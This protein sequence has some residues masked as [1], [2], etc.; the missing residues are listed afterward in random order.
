MHFAI[1]GLSIT[2]SWG[3]GHAALWRGLCRALNERG[4]TIHFFEKDVPYYAQARD[5][6]ELDDGEVVLY[7]DWRS[8][9]SKARRVLADADVGIITSYYPD[10][11]Q[12]AALL[13]DSRAMSVFYDLDSPITLTRLRAGQPVEYVLPDGLARFDLV[14]SYAGGRAL[15]LL[16]SELGAKRVSALCG[17]ADPQL[18]FPQPPRS[19]FRGDLSYLGTYSA[20]RQATL[21]ELLIEPARELP[22]K[23][24]V[25][26]GAQYPDSF[27]WSKNIH[28]VRHLPPCDHGAFYCSSPLTLNVTR[29][30]MAEVGH[31]PSGRLFEAALCGVPVLSDYWPGLEEFFV[32]GQ[33]ILVARTRE[34]T[35]EALEMPAEELSRIGRAAYE[36]TL[37]DH[38]ASVR[39]Q[40]LEQA[41]EAAT[42][43][44]A[45]NC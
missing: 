16:Q 22:G 41:L 14:L 18:H 6:V 10:V 2:S 34:D 32:P 23:T 29:R 24:F 31:C 26:G 28:F 9:A 5:P 42:C 38:T 44:V 11:V 35:I 20:D 8:V 25:L 30:A 39:A 1:F 21:E 40:Q 19:E 45:Q 13:S 4:H 43:S 27:P 15:E 17:W 37:A 3:N 36:R 7:A 33:E 12:A